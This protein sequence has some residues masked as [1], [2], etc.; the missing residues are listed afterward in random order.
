MMIKK[1]NG[2]HTQ[3]QQRLTISAKAA[4]IQIDRKPNKN[5]TDNIILSIKEVRKHVNCFEIEWKNGG[6]LKHGRRR[7]EQRVYG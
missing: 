5:V 3:S 1:F 6:S 4:Q 2:N 7:H